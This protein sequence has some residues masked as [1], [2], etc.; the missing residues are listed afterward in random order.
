LKVNKLQ[1]E[2]GVRLASMALCQFV[3]IEYDSTMI[4][5]DTVIVVNSPLS[6]YLEPEQALSSREEYKLLQQSVKAEELQTQIKTGEY[7]PEVGIGVSGYYTNLMGNSISNGL[8]FA[9]IKVPISGLWEA[10]HTI[11]EHQIKEEIAR[12]NSQNNTELLL[13][14]IQKVWN[15][16]IEAYKQIDV[17]KVSIGQATE[18]LEI[19][20]DNYN[21]GLVNIS[22]MIEAQMLLQQAENRLIDSQVN[23]QL[24]L[25]SY[26]Q[27]TGRYQ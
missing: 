7:M 3:G 8:A 23:Y 19:N 20:R 21:A 18:N 16:L 11:K 4:L 9:T 2:N 14:Q 26:L 27:A 5:A 10:T 22:D 15:E 25:T 24:K 17:A 1:L 6:V 12:N 13:L